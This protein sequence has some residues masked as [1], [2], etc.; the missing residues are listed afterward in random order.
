MRAR[1]RMR[2]VDPAG[3]LARKQRRMKLWRIAAGIIVLA[4]FTV[5]G[6]LL[7]AA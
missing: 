4:G 7:L 1:Y 5:P 6:V 2:Y 3:L